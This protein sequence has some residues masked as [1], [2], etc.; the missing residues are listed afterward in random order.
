LLESLRDVLDPAAGIGFRLDRC[1]EWLSHCPV[2]RILATSREPL[3]VS[4]EQVLRVRSLPAPDAGSDNK[5]AM[6]ADAVRLF[7]ERAAAV[8]RD[9]RLDPVG[10]GAVADICR[11]LDGIP[12]AIELAASQ[13]AALSPAEIAGLLDERFR[14]LTGDRRTAVERHRTLR[15][16]VDW[17]YSLLS[18]TE[19]H[20]FDRL[21]VFAG[22]F[23]AAAAVAVAGGD[24]PVDWAAR[25]ALAGLVHKSMV[26]RVATHP[27]QPLSVV[28]DPAG[29]RPGPSG[30]ARRGRP[31]PPRPRP[32][33]RPAG[34]TADPGDR[35]GN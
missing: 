5:K 31:G 11:R 24:G 22:S 4:G 18:P 27:G 23:D 2:V 15:A 7:A 25:Q 35:D 10:L 33:L 16:T 17:S 26:N 30:R 13:V 12:L 6:R 21:R 9:F 19:R 14:L 29:L 1:T 28:G 32:L 3:G 8:D 20:L 34:R